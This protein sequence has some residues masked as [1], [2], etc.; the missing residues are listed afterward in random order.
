[1]QFGTYEGVFKSERSKAR[2]WAKQKGGD[3]KSVANAKK[4]Y[5]SK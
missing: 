3:N 1:M 2:E 5:V 4:T